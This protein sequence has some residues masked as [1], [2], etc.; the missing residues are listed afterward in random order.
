MTTYLA[1]DLGCPPTP[2]PSNWQNLSTVS[3][4]QN[5]VDSMSGQLGG[6]LKPAEIRCFYHPVHLSSLLSK[7]KKKS[8]I[9]RRWKKGGCFGGQVDTLKNRGAA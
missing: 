3:T 1:V 4:K 8:N 2:T 6:H 9:Y 5:W 7:G